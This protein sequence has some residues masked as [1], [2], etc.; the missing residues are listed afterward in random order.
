[1]KL[2]FLGTASSVETIDRANTSLWYGAPDAPILIDCNGRTVQRL[3]QNNIA[4]L[5]VQHIVF[6]HYHM[7]HI[8]GLPSLLGQIDTI[9]RTQNHVLGKKEPYHIH[10]YLEENT[11]NYVACLLAETQNFLENSGIAIHR[12]IIE[13]DKPFNIGQ[14]TLTP[15]DVQHGP[16]P[17]V[18]F[19]FEHPDAK[20]V[21]Y[22][23]DTM[24]CD[25]IYNRILPHDIIVHQ[26]MYYHDKFLSNRHTHMHQIY[27]IAT[28][29]HNHQFYLV[30]MYAI[31]TDEAFWLKKLQADFGG[32]VTIAY[33]NLIVEINR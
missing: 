7:D 27:D 15:F 25:N 19:V 9:K 22:T 16:T 18:G 26:C 1:M 21:V 32:R 11:A 31:E 3:L 13:A 8:S 4:L 33:D 24:P 6:T 5:D 20:R 17:C 2:I 30:H 14:T 10:L 28:R 12:H 23:A 29:F